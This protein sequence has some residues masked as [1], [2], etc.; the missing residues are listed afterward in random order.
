VSDHF[1]TLRLADDSAQDQVGALLTIVRRAAEEPCWCQSVDRPCECLG[2]N[3]LATLRRI[4]N[5]SS[6]PREPARSCDLC[7]DTR[8]LAPRVARLL[9]APARRGGLV[10]CLSHVYDATCQLVRARSGPIRVEL[11]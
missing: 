6:A 8:W 9:L 10:V 7:R 3:A 1:N 11:I 2:P 4:E 5:P